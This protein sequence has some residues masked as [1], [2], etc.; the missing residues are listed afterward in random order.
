MIIPLK[1]L[2][3]QKAN[4]FKVIKNKQN[5]TKEMILLMILKNPKHLLN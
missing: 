3:L 2:T 4:H 5:L 1:I